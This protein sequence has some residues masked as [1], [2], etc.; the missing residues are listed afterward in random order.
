MR[1]GDSHPD[2]LHAHKPGIF[3]YSAWTSLPRHRPQTYTKGRC[4]YF[5]FSPWVALICSDGHLLLS[6]CTG[7]SRTASLL[8]LTCLPLSAA[9]S[10]CS[11][12]VSSKVISLW[13]RNTKS[14]AWQELNPIKPRLVVLF[15]FNLYPSLKGG[16]GG[17]GK[18]GRKQK[19]R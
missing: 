13:R 17:E 14:L 16:P 4:Y 9:L 3:T 10:L 2:Q 1:I 19:A 12:K 8:P 5:L 15:S 6:D 18:R 7:R 11:A